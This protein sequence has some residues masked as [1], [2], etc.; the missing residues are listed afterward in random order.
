MKFM[1]I[2]KKGTFVVMILLLA[3]SIPTNADLQKRSM[4][5]TVI[6]LKLHPSALPEANA[7][8][9]GG[10]IHVNLTAYGI[11]WSHSLQETNDT[12]LEMK[13][14][15]TVNYGYIIFGGL[16]KYNKTSNYDGF[17]TIKVMDNNNNS[18]II[19]GQIGIPNPPE[20][21][22]VDQG[23]DCQSFHQDEEKICTQTYGFE[24]FEIR[25]RSKISAKIYG[26][27]TSAET[28]FL[29]LPSLIGVYALI[30][31]KERGPKMIHP[32]IMSP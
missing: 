27:S 32:K 26:T 25:I 31:A 18:N 15:E 7:T 22:I 1:R 28:P 21:T 6:W 2:A 14:D 16:V 29:I 8:D 30:K 20:E 9:V 19:S 12:K 5:I 24:H 3:I 13:L 4:T 10:F 11:T 17:V 23:G